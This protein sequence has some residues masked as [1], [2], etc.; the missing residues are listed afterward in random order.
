MIIILYQWFIVF[1]DFC[2]FIWIH[3]Q[4]LKY[5]FSYLMQACIDSRNSLIQNVGIL[6]LIIEWNTPW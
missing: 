5:E 3:I 6:H 4:C 1:H 2:V